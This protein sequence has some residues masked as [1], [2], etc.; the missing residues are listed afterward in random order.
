MTLPP[1]LS[2]MAG[3]RMGLV[4]SE[5]T[6][7]RWLRHTKRFPPTTDRLAFSHLVWDGKLEKTRLQLSEAV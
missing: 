1:A 5:G 6:A 7:S 4:E 2:Q 3:I